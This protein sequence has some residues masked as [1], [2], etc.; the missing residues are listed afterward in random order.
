MK[1]SQMEIMGLAIIVILISIGMLFAIKFVVFKKPE[2][3]K[4]EYTKTE[5][6]SNILTSLMR[7]TMEGCSDLS[8]EDIYQACG[9]DPDNPPVVCS[10]AE[11]ACQFLNR[12]TRRILNLTLVEWNKGYELHASTVTDSIIDVGRCPGA[13]K[14]KP[15]TI[16]IDAS[17]KNS[18]K[19]TLDVCDK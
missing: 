7:T 1:R 12:T 16:P 18:L 6:A 17:S 15:Y 11:D 2:P 5:L 10:P 14:Q 9:K 19:I 4:S 13:K 3:F 8:M